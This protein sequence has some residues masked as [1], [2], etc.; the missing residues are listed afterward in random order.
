VSWFKTEAAGRD[1]VD[2]LPQRDSPHRAISITSRPRLSGGRLNSFERCA[3]NLVSDRR[4]MSVF[5]LAMNHSEVCSKSGRCRDAPM[6][7]AVKLDLPKVSRPTTWYRWR[8]IQMTGL[9]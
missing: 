3:R 6:T 1:L 8:Q 4:R 2:V 5:K 9:Q 7:P